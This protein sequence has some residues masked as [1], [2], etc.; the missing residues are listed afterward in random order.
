MH[1]PFASLSPNRFVLKGFAK[2]GRDLTDKETRA[3]LTAADKDGDGKIGVDG[4]HQ[5]QI[6]LVG[7]SQGHP[8]RHTAAQRRKKKDREEGE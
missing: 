2:D 5:H 4:K 6:P 7:V 3:F 8:R 1:V